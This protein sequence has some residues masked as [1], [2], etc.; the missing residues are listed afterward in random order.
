VG[1]WKDQTEIAAHWTLDR[2]FEPGRNAL[3]MADLRA[4]WNRAVQRASG[5]V[6]REET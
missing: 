3:D 2:R 6:I 4:Q 1:Y 5:W